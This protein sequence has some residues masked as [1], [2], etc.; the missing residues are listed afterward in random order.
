M[1]SD[2]T[3]LYLKGVVKGE[4]HDSK[5]K[6]SD[7]YQNV[8]LN[9]AP[10]GYGEIEALAPPTP[11][12]EEPEPDQSQEPVQEPQQ[13]PQEN[14]PVRVRKLVKEWLSS[15]EFVNAPA[16]QIYFDIIESMNYGLDLDLLENFIK[17]K[18]SSTVFTDAMKSWTSSIPGSRSIQ[19]ELLIPQI[20]L[21]FN[22]RNPDAESG[23]NRLF[24]EIAN[25]AFAEG[26]VSVG[27]FE[28]VISLF[29]EATKGSVGDLA[30]HL[31]DKNGQQIEVKVGMAR[32][33]SQRKAGYQVA[34]L[35]I[36]TAILGKQWV[37][38]QSKQC[39]DNI[40]INKFDKKGDSWVKTKSSTA[41]Y[42]VD[43]RAE[44]DDTRPLTKEEFVEVL[45]TTVPEPHNKP[46]IAADKHILKF[47]ETEDPNNPDL[48][49]RDT[50]VSTAMIY[51]YANPVSGHGFQKILF[52]VSSGEG[53][54]YHRLKKNKDTGEMENDPRRRDMGPGLGDFDSVFVIDTSSDRGFENIFNAINQKYVIVSRGTKPL[55]IEGGRRLDGEGVYMQGTGDTSIESNTD[56]DFR[57]LSNYG[58]RF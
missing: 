23:V 8:L 45:Q 5:A 35:A 15:T 39:G 19:Q 14:V 37:E 22:N 25:Y 36:E 13:K 33:V 17:A 9:E 54:A 21:I 16:K 7:M 40:A 10:Y 29:T 51:E 6:L 2:I 48:E 11:S 52:V 56:N 20:R 12:S 31:E 3:K 41:P 55:G 53:D 27:K 50:L 30:I 44:G 1:N 46:F 26:T 34:N 18:K 58:I 4:H 38:P 28:L 57:K 32:V 47:L 43:A 24:E 42:K 49:L